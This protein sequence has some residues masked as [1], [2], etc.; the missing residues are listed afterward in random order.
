MRMNSMA[1]STLVVAS[2]S[3]AERIGSMA[4]MPEEEFP[5]FHCGN[6]DAGIFGQMFWERSSNKR[7]LIGGGA[8]IEVVYS[9]SSVRESVVVHALP[10]Q[11]TQRYARLDDEE[12]REFAASWSRTN[13]HIRM[14]RSQDFYERLLQ[15]VACLARIAVRDQRTLFVRTQFRRPHS[16]WLQPI[17]RENAP[18]G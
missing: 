5:H 17:G 8:R 6:L 16:K 1:N 4:T 18:S 11:V 3:D 7:E 10:P 12:V 2:H 15:A 14:P 13:D 9:S